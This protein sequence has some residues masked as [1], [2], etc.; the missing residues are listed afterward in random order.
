MHGIIWG[1]GFG[2]HTLNEY[3]K[4]WRWPRG[5]AHARKVCLHDDG[6][7]RQTANGTASELWSLVPVLQKFVQYVVEPGASQRS[8]LQSPA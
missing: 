3:I 8:S 5:S 4:L 7:V 2:M 6:T 1:D